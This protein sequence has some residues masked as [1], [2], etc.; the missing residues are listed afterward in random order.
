MNGTPCLLRSLYS[1]RSK[2]L[3]THAENGD[4]LEDIIE[5]GV[6]HLNGDW[7]AV[8]KYLIDTWVA[9]ALGC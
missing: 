1:S 3:A 6:S 5:G 9:D 4:N 2:S 8:F 7:H